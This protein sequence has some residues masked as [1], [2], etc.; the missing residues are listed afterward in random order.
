VGTAKRERQKQN[1]Q[2]KLEELAKQQK[3]EQTKRKTIRWGL[4]GALILIGIG[5]ITFATTGS[6][7][8]IGSSKD[9]SGSSSAD[10]TVVSDTTVAG[11]DTTTATATTVA[12]DVPTTVPGGSITGET[13]CPPAEGATE[14][15]VTFEQAPPMCIDAA[16]TYT[17]T[18]TT[19]KGEFTV[20]LDP[21]AAPNTVNNFVV[22]SRYGYYDGTVCHRIIKDFV[23]Q[24]GDPSG[25]GN[26]DGGT[27]P[28]YEFADEL[29]AAGSY[30]LGSLAMA[31]AGPDTNGSQ[32][33]IITGEQGT[34]LPPS[35]SLFGQVSQGFDT[36]VK[37]ME[38]AANPDPTKNGSPTLEPIVIEKVTITES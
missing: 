29:P 31:N 18:V 24:C 5:V 22:L 13:P 17:A 28:G 26:G 30:Q 34:Q 12:Q 6:L 37:A 19:N 15:I 3:K 8:G 32:F 36:T 7:F 4:I 16:K 38:A 2:L 9:D 27:Y 11:T 23:V 25:T 21:K 33:F 1:R 10:T 35:Y 20:D 14:R